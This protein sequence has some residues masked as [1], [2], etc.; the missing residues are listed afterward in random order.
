MS[1]IDG[2]LYCYFTVITLLYMQY[3]YDYNCCHFTSS[4]FVITFVFKKVL[5]IN[6]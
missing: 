4:E 2:A 6:Q 1:K 3:M 5:L